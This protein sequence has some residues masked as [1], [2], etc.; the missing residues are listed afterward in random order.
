MSKKKRNIVIDTNVMLEHMW[1][2]LAPRYA[3]AN[4]RESARAVELALQDYQLCVS[5][6]TWQEFERVASTARHGGT[7]PCGDDRLQH[8]AAMR[9]LV[10]FKVPGRSQVP[11]R[12]NN[13]RMFRHL[14]AGVSAHFILTRDRHLLAVPK[15]GRRLVLTPEDF[16]VKAIR[17]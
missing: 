12:D 17:P 13:D 3:N 14:A 10:C 5:G 9:E 1:A 7:F 4:E 6:P 16:M 11:C 2:A 8:V 15:E